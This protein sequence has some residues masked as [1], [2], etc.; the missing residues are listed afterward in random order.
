MAAAAEADQ[1][2]ADLRS[3]EVKPIPNV[4]TMTMVAHDYV[5][6]APMVSVQVGVLLPI[7]DRNQGNIAS[8][9]S[10]T[11]MMQ[12][13]IELAR[14]RMMERLTAAYQRYENARRQAE[15]YRTIILSQA[16]AALEQIEKIYDLRGERFTD[17]LD[18]RRT[19]AQARIEYAQLQGEIWIAATEIE[20]IVQHPLQTPEQKE[21]TRRGCAAE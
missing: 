16:T 21:R 20:S 6:R 1:A 12:S 14:L 13:G 4:Q 15:R 8:A 5:T 17:T 7:L 11:A 19:L 2:R 10:R 18:A 9:R 3:A